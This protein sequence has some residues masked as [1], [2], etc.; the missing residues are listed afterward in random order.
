MKIESIEVINSGSR[1]RKAIVTMLIGSKYLSDWNKVC[2]RNWSLYCKK[3]D[4]DIVLIK[5]PLSTDDERNNRSVHWDKLLIKRIPVCAKYDMVAWIDADIIMNHR[6]APDLFA[7]FDA[8]KI[9]AVSLMHGFPFDLKEA[10]RRVAYLRHHYIDAK[11]PLDSIILADDNLTYK[12]INKP[13]LNDFINTGVLVY[14]LKR[15]G[16]FL[17]DVF[18][19]YKDETVFDGFEQCHLSY[20]I[21]SNSI[22]HQMPYKFNAIWNY[23]IAINYPFLY[24]PSEQKNEL[25]VKYCK[26]TT[27]YNSYFLHFPGWRFEKTHFYHNFSE[28]EEDSFWGG[29]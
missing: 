27:L 9:G 6:K 1:S 4:I 21:I 11:Y 19:K 8:S 3:H 23:E 10:K 17:E 12:L 15:Y 28:E 18:R 14:N 24:F 13:V 20:E 16:G 2:R 26:Y 25:L 29:E 22:Y 7:A 5:Q